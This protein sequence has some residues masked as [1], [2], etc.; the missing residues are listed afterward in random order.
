VR[1]YITFQVREFM[2]LDV[3]DGGGVISML[4]WVLTEGWK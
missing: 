4:A 1:R 2:K 3:E